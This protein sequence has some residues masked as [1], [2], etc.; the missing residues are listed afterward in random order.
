MIDAADFSSGLCTQSP[1]PQYQQCYASFIYSSSKITLGKINFTSS[2]HRFIGKSG[3]LY[4]VS[5]MHVTLLNLVNGDLRPV[6]RQ[7][8]VTS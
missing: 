1:H 4:V 5:E 2:L 7:N 3:Y 8:K 6:F